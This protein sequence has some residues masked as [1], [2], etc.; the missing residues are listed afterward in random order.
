M[1]KN[2][3]KLFVIGAALIAL[4]F[5]GQSGLTTA[6]PETTGQILDDTLVGSGQFVEGLE[7]VAAEGSAL[8]TQY[9]QYGGEKIF[10]LDPSQ[11]AF[12]D[13]E[14][15]YA[16]SSSQENWHD[17]W[18]RSI[19][20]FRDGATVVFQFSQ[21][22]EQS[23]D[24]GAEI[25]EALSSWMGTTLDVLYGAYDPTTGRT[26]LFYWGYMSAQNHTDFIKDEFYSV[27]DASGGF[28]NFIEDNVVAS[29][30]VSVVG[31]GLVKSET[32]GWVP[33]TVAAFIEDTAIVIDD[34]NVHNLSL[35][36]A[37]GYS[38][39][40][41]PSSGAYYSVI[42]FQLPYVANV[43]DL[44]PETDNL[45]P[46]LT[47]EYTW[48]LKPGDGGT[49]YDSYEDIYVT[50]DMALDQLESFP[51]I[52]G[53]VSVDVAALHSDVNPYLNYTIS[54][55]NT[56]DETAYGTTFA[57]D[58]GE[59]PQSQYISVFNS[60]KYTFN[61]SIEKYFNMS[62]GL[63]VDELAYTAIYDQD[64]GQWPN[65]SLAIT[66]WFT[67]NSDGDKVVQ[68]QYIVH[69]GAGKNG[70]D[71]FELDYPATLETVYINKSF[72]NFTKSDNLGS[73][74]DDGKFY[75]TATI[76]ELEQ[77]ATEKFWWAVKD[78][79]SASD[80]FI[81]LGFNNTNEG[82]QWFNDGTT[83]YLQI[84]I[85]FID[86]TTEMTGGITNLKDYIVK[87][88]LSEGSD[89][90]YPPAESEFV[91]GVMFRYEDNAS[92]EYFGWSNG[93]VIQLYDDEA[94]LKTT[95]ALN[96]TIYRID[97]WAEINVTIENIGDATA[98][99]VEIQ[100]F[101]AQLGP[102]WQLTGIYNF[103]DTTAIGTIAPGENKT[104]TF[105]RR[106]STFLGIHPVV[107]S[108]KYTTE[109]DEGYD[110]AFNRTEIRGVV[111][112]LISSLV[113]PKVDKAGEDE[114][115]YP[116]PEINV[117]VT[118]TDENGGYIEDGDLIEIRTE[119]KN[120]GDEAT[121]I[122][123]F[124]YFPSRMARIDPYAN[125]YDG[126]N[127]K[128]T[129]V[130]GN[131][132]TDYTE[133]FALE[134]PDWPISVAAVAGLHLAPGA[135]IVFY[136]KLIVKDAGSLILP[137]VA[138]EYDSRYPMAGT[139]GMEGGGGEAETPPLAASMHLKTNS[140]E[141]NPIRRFSI[142]ND[143]SA[144]STWTS[145]SNSALLS[146]F[147]AV[148]VVK[149]TTTGTEETPPTTPTGFVNG[150]TTMTSFIRNNMTL[151]IAVLA[152]PVIVLIEREYRRKK[153]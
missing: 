23:L 120:I 142:Q 47:G 119:V 33:L 7:L 130:S 126:K 88:T 5:S 81:V 34:N 87:V 99:N 152:I 84:N 64:S 132:L 129:D 3:M 63:L 53:D 136:Y 90:R 114:P 124:S 112:N 16:I 105:I 138:V 37:F 153:K 56:G 14:V 148:N 15:L 109:E 125:Y 93:L 123:V 39:T 94:I 25:A 12:N 146:T 85:T 147:A 137:P 13:L 98:T 100:G 122:K 28:A 54:M 20:E 72:F 27:M 144:T 82:G 44:Y 68:P 92:R 40:I 96:S 141:K 2:E 32:G 18:P 59:E 97:D 102:D 140:A 61:P 8:I 110:G 57:W 121:T 143:D 22:L 67:N 71:I 104:H 133:G 115:S 95:V 43:Y 78:L 48:T 65:I 113:L 77:D 117:S 86:N 58:L 45:Y 11:P 70:E 111:S 51:Q 4:V 103:S 74:I 35:K 6:A 131:K 42:K 106:V 1:K 50:Y 79:P 101:H 149:T 17:Y 24:D 62:S 46:E 10:P 55:T 60:E 107:A 26:T 41:Q 118:W 49:P 29:A 52:T 38:G 135:T 36:S 150:F 83:N 127:F 31:T 76:D 108:V 128:V 134:H 91:P 89:L 139:S 21:G 116:T 80:E 9:Y 19:W 151:M 69:A 145:T 75:L 66:G 73:F 30:P